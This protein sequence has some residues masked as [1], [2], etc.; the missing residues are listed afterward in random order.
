[1]RMS[2]KGCKRA[3]KLVKRG[4]AHLTFVIL[5]KCNKVINDE[6]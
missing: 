3:F 6:F 2:K 4:T 1:M 5:K